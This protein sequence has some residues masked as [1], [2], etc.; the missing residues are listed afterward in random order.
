MFRLHNRIFPVAVFLLAAVCCRAQNY[1]IS[2]FAGQGLALGDGASAANAR[3]GVIS[4]IAI[5]PDGSLY[6]ADS[7]YHQVRRVGPDGSISLF[8]GGPVRGFGGD[9]G[10]ATAA[11]LDTPTALVVDSGGSVYIGDSGNHRVRVVT[12]Y[13]NITTFA[14]NGQLAPSPAA[15]PVLPGEGGPATGAPLNQISALAFAS[16][17]DM[18]IADSGNNRIFR[19][20][21]GSGNIATLA[22]NATTPASLAAQPALSATLNGPSGVVSDYLGNIYFSEPASGVVRQIDPTG[23]LTS[24]IGPGSALTYPLLQPTG[25]TIDGNYNIYIAEAGRISMYSPQN[26]GTGAIASVQAFA[27]DLTQTVTSGT[28]DGGLPLS[29]GMNPRSLAVDGRFS[30]Y[31]ADSTPTLNFF[32][33]V[34]VIAFSYITET[35]IINAFA[36]GNRPSGKGDKGPATSAQLSFPQ[37]VTI[38]PKGTV[39]IAD[40][41]DNRVRAVTADGNINAFAGNGTA[42][43]SGDQGPAVLASLNPPTGLAMDTNSNVYIADGTRIRLVNP[44]G[45]ITTFAGGGSSTQEGAPALSASLVQNGS[46]AVDSHNNVFVDQMARVSEVSAANQTISTVAGNGTVGYSGDAGPA[47]AAQI[48]DRAGIAVDSS[49]NLYIADEDNGR[50]RKVDPTGNITTIAGGGT[51]T[52]DGVSATSAAL[53]IPLGVALDSMGNLYIAEYGGNRVRMVD[54][55]GVIHTIAGNGLQGFS[56]DG[57]VATNAS[58]NG[59]TDV[60]VDAQGNLYIADS[61]N[62]SIRKLTPIAVLPTPLIASIA[63]AGSFAGGPV[64][65]GE[66]VILTGT[67]LGPNS[68]VMFDGTPAP[69]LSSSLTSTMVVVPNEVSI[70]AVSQV[71]VITSGVTSPAFAVQIAPSA[72]GIYTMSGDGQGQAFAYND[73]GS[74]NSTNAALA[75][76]SVNILCTGAGLLSPSVATGVLVPPTTPSPV[77]PVSATLDG[78]PLPVNQAYAIP[79]T[80]GQFVVSVGLPDSAQ[81]ESSAAIQITVGAAASQTASIAVQG[82]PPDSGSGSDSMLRRRLA[83]KRASRSLPPVR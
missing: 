20:S 79:G 43:T 72:P 54:A 2:T 56:G 25:L 64:A 77:L 73:D 13:G 70:E 5:G 71:T 57:S 28:G 9:G 38:D 22:G 49:G 47:Q 14:G 27:G 19:V 7:A 55:T 65:P 80:L 51:S 59:P 36:G 37:A 11:L 3:F 61:L 34:R 76:S 58:L 12:G 6:I 42:G 21:A 23:N 48:D 82:V 81:S 40:T 46:L 24:L 60:K 45:T 66:R 4:A 17:S 68:K 32:N 83:P 33:R 30:V 29:A 53:N 62:S 26:F 10:P 15:A 78:L 52:A 8:A 31:L 74:L 41:A 75:G 16:N 69:V 50:I 44:A 18:L 1:A 63:N 39:Y 35:N 67:A